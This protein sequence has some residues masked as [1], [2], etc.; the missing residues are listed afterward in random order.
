MGAEQIKTE[1]SGNRM[2]EMVKSFSYIREAGTE[3]ERRAADQLAAYLKEMNAFGSALISV[4]RESFSFS[5]MKQEKASLTV[6]EPYQKTYSVT[7]CRGAVNTPDGGITAPFVYVEDADEISLGGDLNGKIVMLNRPGADRQEVWTQLL[8]TKAATVLVVC[9]SLLDVKEDQTAPAVGIG[10]A[11]GTLCAAAIHASAAA[12][13]VTEGAAVAHLEAVQNP[14]TKRSENLS[15]R[16]EGSE[17][18]DE[19]LTLTA[20]YDSVPAGPGAYDNM[21]ACAILAELCRYFA[22]NR[23]QRTLEFVWFGAEETGLKGSIAYVKAHEEEFKRHIVN[24]NVDLAGQLLGGNVLGITASE[25]M[26]KRLK[27]AAQTS[28]IGF[29]VK[30][31]IWSSDSNSFA[32]K[33][34]P[35]MTLNRDGVGM[36]TRFDTVDLISPWSLERSAL[37]LGCMAEILADTEQ[38]FSEE[39]RKIPEEFSLPLTHSFQNA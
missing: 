32:W 6:L 11:S 5:A 12:E 15:V 31:Q 2:Y 34:I 8:Q 24:L 9:G 7:V 25:A 33:G 37:L 29:R 28:G 36:H 23:P 20:H 26:A 10:A 35:A 19:V 17:K 30:R 39:E 14:K 1:I 27:T 3:G 21:S 22:K 16:L 18:P 13:L 4:C 38:D